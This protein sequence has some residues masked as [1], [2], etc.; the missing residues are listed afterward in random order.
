[1]SDVAREY[2]HGEQR[3]LGSYVVLTGGFFAAF[4]GALVAARAGGREIDRPALADVALGA[5]ATQKGDL[6]LLSD[7]QTAA[8]ITAARRIGNAGARA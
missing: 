3:P 7:A 8:L 1:M 2:A 6:A 5:L 4:A